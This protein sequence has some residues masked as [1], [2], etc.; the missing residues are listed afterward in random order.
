M[1]QQ[2]P[3]AK[4]YKRLSLARKRILRRELRRFKV[5]RNFRSYDDYMRKRLMQDEELQRLYLEECRQD[6]HPGLYEGALSDVLQA[7]YSKFY[8]FPVN[9]RILTE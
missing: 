7:R 6:P 5:R 4:M 3:R 1:A 2:M 8:Y 9:D